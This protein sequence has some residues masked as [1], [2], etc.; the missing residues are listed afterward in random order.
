MT[1]V[2]GEM[3]GSKWV[4]LWMGMVEMPEG[5]TW[6]GPNGDKR[7][8]DEAGAMLNDNNRAQIIHKLLCER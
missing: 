7:D 5:R 1:T 4:V 8:T 6:E 3:H 2:D